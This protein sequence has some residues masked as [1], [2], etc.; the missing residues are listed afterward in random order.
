MSD[1]IF[2][3]GD[4]G[5]LSEV[6]SRPFDAEA[7]LQQLL[8]DHVHLLPGAQIN[9]D[10]PRRW[11]LIKREAG[12]PNQEGGGDWWSVD[13][14]V[15]DQDAVPTFVEVKRASDTRA[16]RE[17]VAQMLDYAANGSALWTP[18]RLRAWFEGDDPEAAA[19]RLAAW[20]KSADEDPESVANAFWDAVGV[21]LREG[22]IRLVFVA[23]EIPS[24]LQRLVEFLNEQMQRVEVVAV[25]IRQYRAAGSKS[26]ALVPRVVGQTSRAQAAKERPASPSRHSARWTGDE[27]LEWISR[28]G[29]DAAAVASAVRD[30][31]ERHPHV[32]VAG[33]TGASY[34][35]ITMSAD[36]GRARSRFR[37]VLSLYG[38]PHGESPMLEIRIK[39]MCRTPPYNQAG[40]RTKLIADLK[41]LGI[42]RLDTEDALPD[43]R[44]NIPLD[45][46]SNGRAER[47]LTLV[48]G[49]IEDI[50]AHAGEP[51]PADES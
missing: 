47:L 40:K 38:S 37:G 50:C 25:E 27:V 10:S 1:S 28:T 6:T 23:D 36:S 4:D 24:T 33:G 19:E 49:W 45:E 14:L 17:V 51:E 34:P 44:P 15:V 46:L 2:L 43:K 22:K 21:N 7:D 35:S 5:L 11:L 31:A 9:R 12:I 30:W 18:E 39:R 32:H 41:S 16:R 8:A 48:S 29:Q 42:P 20:L 3:L 13:H 26:G